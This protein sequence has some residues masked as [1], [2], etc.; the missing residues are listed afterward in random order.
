[1]IFSRKKDEVIAPYSIEQCT[2][3]N[4]T[5]KRKFADGDYVF[6]M[7]GDCTSCNKG[8]IIISRIYGETVK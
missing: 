8:K 7:L 3:C 6:R 2:S 5:R 1:M 4:L